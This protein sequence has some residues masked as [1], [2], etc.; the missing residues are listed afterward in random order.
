MQL[1]MSCHNAYVQQA[2]N[3]S[4]GATHGN[5]KLQHTMFFFWGLTK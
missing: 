5:F 1:K 4:S 2:G 3:T